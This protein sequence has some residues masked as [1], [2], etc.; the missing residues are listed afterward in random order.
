MLEKAKNTLS[1]DTDDKYQ[2]PEI[3]NRK[4]ETRNRFLGKPVSVFQKRVFQKTGASAATAE[5]KPY[6]V[7]KSIL[8][9]LKAQQHQTVN[10][11][12]VLNDANS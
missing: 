2:K 5:N 9:G 7:I 3:G 10:S 8:C 4:P 6:I 11:K 12:K 1:C